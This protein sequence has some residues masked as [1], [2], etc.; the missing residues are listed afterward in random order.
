MKVAI[1]AAGDNRKYFPLFFNK[2]KCL[3]HQNGVVQIERVINDVKT[4]VSEKDIII[5]GGYKFNELEKYIKEK[6]PLITI[7]NNEKYLESAIY[8]FRKAVENIEDD[9]VFMFGDESISQ[10]KHSTNCQLK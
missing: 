8:S 9:F 1:L 2:P 3:Y 6:H 7:R 5:V 4:I 10:K